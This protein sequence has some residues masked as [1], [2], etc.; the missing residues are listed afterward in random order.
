MQPIVD[1]IRK[2]FNGCLKV[3]RVNYHEWTQWHELI[4]PVGSPELTLL[5][6]SNTILYRWFGFT[7]TDEIEQVLLPL[8]S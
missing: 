5:D 2:K 4:F 1:G 7:E 8:C 6:A 3:E